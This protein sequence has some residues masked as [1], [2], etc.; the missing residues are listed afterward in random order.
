MKY[1]ILIRSNSQ[2]FY[3]IVSNFVIFSIIYEDQGITKLK[4]LLE[5]ANFKL[6]VVFKKE[7]FCIW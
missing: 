2:F 4:R 1:S 6:A 7:T 5:R 3:Q